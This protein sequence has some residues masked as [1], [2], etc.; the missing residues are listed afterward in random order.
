MRPGVRIAALLLLASVAPASGQLRYT[1]DLSQPSTHTAAITLRVGSL[2]EADS[3]FQFAATAPGTYQTMNIG[4][5]VHGLRALDAR[6]RTVPTIRASA[7][8][9]VITQPRR[10]RQIEYRIDDTW[11]HPVAEFGIYPMAGSEIDSDHALLNAHALLGFPRRMQATPVTMRLVHPRGWR[12]YTV[13]SEGPHGFEATSYDHAVDSPILVGE[14]IT[15]ATLSVA[16]APVR[17]ASYSPGNHITATQLSEAM[18]G[19]LVAAGRFIGCLP[20]DRYV[21]LYRFSPP[22]PGDAMGAWEHGSSSEYVLLNEP[23]TPRVGAQITDIA[24]HE[25][26]HVVTP[27]NVHS[28]IIERFNFERPVPSL[29]LWLYEGTTEWASTKMQQEGGLMDLAAY[30]GQQI[31]KA[32]ADR[33]RYDTA[34][35]LTDLART[36]FTTAGARQYGNVYSRGALVAGLLDIRLLQLSG[37]RR[38]LRQLVRELARDYGRARPFPED[39]L[40]ELV[41]ARTHPEVRDFFRRY[42]EGHERP[43]LREYYAALGIDLVEDAAGLPLRFEVKADPTPEQLRLRE[44]WL[45]SG[46]ESADASGATC[47]AR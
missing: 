26:F 10:V 23:F 18:R 29:H 15:E 42:V 39:S 20:V 17:I 7:N 13:L 5:F 34:Q 45:R 14:G 1:I 11:N 35:S 16:G 47:S 36:S 37:G 28:E 33:M 8:S 4:R 9:W 2:A 30:L 46:T 24:S 3:V 6:G 38:G 12:A 31:A 44:A 41:T 19:M 25:F 21:F 32:R 27:L 40:F 22:R 43:P